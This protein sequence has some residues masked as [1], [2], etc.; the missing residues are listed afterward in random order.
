MYKYR[1]L[2]MNDKRRL[3]EG[4]VVLSALC[5]AEAWKMEAVE[6]KRLNVKEMDVSVK[7]LKKIS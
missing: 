1:S 5:G 2:G 3:Y 6:T 4:I 7:C